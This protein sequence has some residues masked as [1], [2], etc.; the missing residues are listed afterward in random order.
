[1]GTLLHGIFEDLD[2]DADD[3]EIMEMIEN[4]LGGYREFSMEGGELRKTWI[5]NKVKTILNKNLGE[6]GKLSDVKADNKVTELNFYMY[7]Q[8]MTLPKIKEIIGNKINN[9]EKDDLLARYIK[10]AIDLVFMGKDGKYYILDWKSNSISDFSKEG[11]DKEA[12]LPHGYHLQYYIY[13]VALKR[14]LEETQ[15]DFDFKKQFGGVY[16]IFIRGVTDKENNNDGIYFADAKEIADN[17]IKLDNSFGR[18]RK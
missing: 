5:K 15:E 12:M 6:A 16:Y 4:K 3:D 14:W 18:S 11:M 17:I 7:S 13:A 2:F 1:M 9:F 8:N 10:G